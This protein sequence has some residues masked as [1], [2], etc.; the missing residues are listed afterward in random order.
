M[1]L[2]LRTISKEEGE[3]FKTFYDGAGHDKKDLEEFAWETFVTI[4]R[5]AGPIL[6]LGLQFTSVATANLVSRQKSVGS[7][8]PLPNISLFANC[9]VWTIYGV[10]KEDG[11]IFFPNSIGIL[12]SLYC[13][14]VFHQ[15]GLAKPFKLYLLAVLVC[16]AVIYLAVDDDTQSI[17]LMGCFMAVL[18][19]AS[20]LAVVR[21][22]IRERSTTSLPFFTSLI[23]WCNALSWFLYGRLVADDELVWVPNALGL[24]LATV[25]LS[26]FAVYGFDVPVDDDGKL[27]KTW[28]NRT[29]SKPK[30]QV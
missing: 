6:F 16:C 29:A 24:M 18:F 2:L 1:R 4:L 22:V 21:T 3:L 23:I 5:C 11:T 14:S 28:I 19:M 7:L 15:H 30:L 8:S 26:L 10:L 25:Q 27:D 17:G 12:T 9:F 13:M 20:P